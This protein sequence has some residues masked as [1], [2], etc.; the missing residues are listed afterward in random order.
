M[1]AF[2]LETV[3]AAKVF[4]TRGKPGGTGA[5]GEGRIQRAVADFLNWPVHRVKDALA[6]LAAIERNELSKEAIEA[7][8]SQKAA[9]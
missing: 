2:V 4:I 8:P 7:L 6:Q 3:S 5:P 1:P 9:T